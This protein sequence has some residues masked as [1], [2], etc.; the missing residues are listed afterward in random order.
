MKVVF[1]TGVEG[2]FAF[3]EGCNYMGERQFIMADN[4]SMYSLS[5]QAQPEKDLTIDNT[6]KINVIL[7]TPLVLS[8]KYK[9]FRRGQLKSVCSFRAG[10]AFYKKG[11]YDTDIPI[12]TERGQ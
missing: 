2:P 6:E 10:P 7:R 5:R 12:G 4:N 8:V 9:E 11:L 3:T 1:S